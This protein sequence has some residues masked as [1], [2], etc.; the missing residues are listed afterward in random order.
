MASLSDPLVRRLLDGRYVASFATHQPGGSIHVVAVWYWF[1]GRDIYVAT[2][3]RSRKARNLEANP[4]ASLMIDARDPAASCGAT[5]AGTTQVLAGEA[6]RKYNAEIYRKY[7]S[8]AAI[9]DPRV[10][11]VFTVWDDVTVRL[12]P[13]SVFAWDLR[14]A[15]EK[16]FGGALKDN[17]AYLLPLDV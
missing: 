14:E 17:P 15:D 4:A 11:P 3:S 1:D 6:S 13:V 5:M 9:A 16:V 7:L 10:G 2:S 12:T 8:A